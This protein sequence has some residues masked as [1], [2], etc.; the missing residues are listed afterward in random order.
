MK[1]IHIENL[2]I[3]DFFDSPPPYA[4]LSH[5]W[6]K[7]EVTFH[8]VSQKRVAGKAGWIKITS[9]CK[10]V[11]KYLLDPV[12]YV[13]VDTCCIDKSS[14]EELSE[15]INSMFRYYKE[16]MS[17][18]VYLTDVVY[19]DPSK[20]VDT[21]F[22]KSRWFTRGWTLQELIAPT[23]L[24]F[25]DKEWRL[26]ETK[27]SLASR[28]SVT[29]RVDEV[30]L[31]SGDWSGASIA[32]R[33]SWA[34]TRETR[35]LEDIA[36][37]LFG[38]FDVHMPLL[39]GEGSR[40]F[41]RLQEEILRQSDDYSLFAW[42]ASMVDESIAHIGVLAAHPILFKDSGTIESYPAAGP[43]S[44]SNLGI[45]ARLSFK[46]NAMGQISV[47]LPCGFAGDVNSVVALG[48]DQFQAEPVIILSR[49]RSKFRVSSTSQT[50]PPE[51]HN[52]FYLLKTSR[53]VQNSVSRCCLTYSQVRDHDRFFPFRLYPH[54]MW[55]SSRSTRSMTLTLPA[56]G[57]GTFKAAVVFRCSAFEGYFAVVLT[58]RCNQMQGNVQ[59]VKG[60]DGMLPDRLE[61]VIESMPAPDKSNHSRLKL[62]II[63]IMATINVK[64]IRGVR[65]FAVTVT[66][67]EP[68]PPRQQERSKKQDSR[69]SHGFSLPF[70]K[71]KNESS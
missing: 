17:C 22:E 3:E 2:D 42:D 54:Q 62:G 12:E 64:T 29:T 52:E 44:I 9:F 20:P 24:M 46:K 11:N 61:E 6:E 51:Q 43:I 1:L 65:M 13:W 33:M 30:T 16:A 48:L 34:A 23:D 41:I 35:R 66:Q 27:V 5:T 36:Y 31:I 32:R 59:L 7:D 28:I 63:N 39:Y 57:D 21:S 45:H 15:G 50:L 53:A 10:I 68:L 38:L 56:D 49:A 70:F 19:S 14:S 58:L 55:A 60:S 26:I 4:I 8:D 37:C 71:K 40:A 47:H 69:T 67:L 25:F 18:F